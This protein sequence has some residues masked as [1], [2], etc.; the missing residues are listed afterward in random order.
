MCAARELLQSYSRV[1]AG[2]QRWFGPYSTLMSRILG[3]ARVL[4]LAP[5]LTDVN[6]PG[7]VRRGRLGAP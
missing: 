4:W 2:G 5:P 6:G 7:R 3:P 1:S